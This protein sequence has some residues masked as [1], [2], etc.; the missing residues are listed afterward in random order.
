MSGRVH[1]SSD[2]GLPSPRHVNHQQTLIKLSFQNDYVGRKNKVRFFKRKRLNCMSQITSF[3]QS[4]G[5]ITY[6]MEKET[7]KHELLLAFDS[8][9]N[10][11]T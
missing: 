2:E 11:N 6:E 10:T 7:V 3:Q 5:V 1:Q 4:G 9:M 8:N